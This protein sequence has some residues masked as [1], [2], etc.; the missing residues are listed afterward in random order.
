MSLPDTYALRLLLPFRGVVQI[1]QGRHAR[2][3][4]DDGIHWQIQVNVE[5]RNP[6][7]GEVIGGQSKPVDM[8]FGSWTARNGLQRLPF[9]PMADIE[10]ACRNAERLVGELEAA[11]RDVPFPMQDTMELWL[12]DTEFRP[13]ALL[14][15]NR[16]GTGLPSRSINRWLVAGP[17]EYPPA[18]TVP[19]R[20]QQL[21]DQINKTTQTKLWI[22]R[23]D[24]GAGRVLN[25]DTEHVLETH[26]TIPPTVFPELLL[27][28]DWPDKD[29]AWQVDAYLMQQ[30]PR[31]LTLPNLSDDTRDR[32]E[33]HARR[34]APAVAHYFRL[35]PKILNPELIDAARVEA[36]M[37]D[38][39]VD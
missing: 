2:A 17:P 28:T 7:W 39:V 21:A 9:D 22:T 24:S 18:L 34:S 19:K 23:D 8:V 10:T 11:H 37:R 29:L 33:R 27:Q 36:R 35:Y 3:L 4:S 16:P 6:I 14:A 15:S 13:S 31:L 38:N 20:N 32:L 5:S 30:A 26:D 1:V 12:S 25:P